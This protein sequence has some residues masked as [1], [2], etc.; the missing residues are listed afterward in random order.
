MPGETH[1]R[2]K[3]MSTNTEK[4]TKGKGPAKSEKKNQPEIKHRSHRNIY[5]LWKSRVAEAIHHASKVYIGTV[6][7][8]RIYGGGG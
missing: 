1:L 7:Q 5:N 6:Q 3:E 4:K 2:S 8:A